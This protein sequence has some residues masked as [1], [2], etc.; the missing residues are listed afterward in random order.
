MLGNL[1]HFLN[2]LISPFVSPDADSEYAP[3]G[4]RFEDDQLE[5]AGGLHKAFPPDVYPFKIRGLHHAFPISAVKNNPRVINDQFA[6]PEPVE[7]ENDQGHEKEEGHD[8][9][10][11]VP[12]DQGKPVLDEISTN[13][14]IEEQGD[15]IHQSLLII[16]I[17]LVSK[18]L[19]RIH[20]VLP[21]RSKISLAM[22]RAASGFA[23]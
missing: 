21:A 13:T 6:V 20:T 17:K 22:I 4:F 9:H 7:E 12:V 1:L 18:D 19:R 15:Q 14:G 23:R 3:A 11:R 8:V 5:P 10:D 2:Q 16:E